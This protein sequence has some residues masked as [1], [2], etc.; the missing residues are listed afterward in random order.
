MFELKLCSSDV[1]YLNMIAVMET[2]GFSEYDLLF[3]IEN[4]Q[5][6]EKGLEMVECNAELQLVKKQAEESKVLNLLVRACPPPCS[7]FERQ[8][9]STVVYEETVLYDLSEPPIMVLMK[10]ELHLKVRVVA[11]V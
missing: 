9:L 11:T 3:H 8:E 1:T 4:P 6:G 10:K 2:Q 7:Q 5:L